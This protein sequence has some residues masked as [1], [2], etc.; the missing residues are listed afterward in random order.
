MSAW[1]GRGEAQEQ[2]RVWGNAGPGRAAG[3][4]T[5]P[6]DHRRVPGLSPHDLL[7][8]GGKEAAA[9]SQLRE[10]SGPT[11]A[12]KAVSFTGL[13]E[14]L[15]VHWNSH[16]WST[17]EARPFPPGHPEHSSLPGQAVNPLTTQGPHS[18]YLFQL[19]V[20]MLNNQV[21]GHSVS[22][23]WSDPKAKQL[24]L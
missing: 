3:R 23:P 8:Q 18:S 24:E 13:K 11:R 19:A 4:G 16:T 10:E 1:E 7:S 21:N 5:H 20:D 15:G 22:T 14:R 9:G 2:W 6:S 12:Q 17:G